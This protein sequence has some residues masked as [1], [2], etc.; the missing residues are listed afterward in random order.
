MRVRTLLNPFKCPQ[1]FTVQS[2][3]EHFCNFNGI[4]DVEIGFGTG[5]FIH[6]YAQSNLNRSIVGFEIRKKLVD[7]AQ[8][9][10]TE[11]ALNNA[12]LVWGNGQFGLEDMF[13]DHSIDRLF[14]FHPDPWEKKRHHKRR[15][16][17]PGF[18]NHAHRKLKQGHSLYVATDVQDL[19]HDMLTTITESG[20]FHQICDDFFWENHYQTRWKEMSQAHNRSLFCGTFQATSPE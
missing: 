8:A 19:W 16:I 14:V 3:Q 18:L 9:K 15:V 17:S 1:R 12:Y 2:W 11:L 13:H 7:H 20:K 5:S 10:V 4:L 6:H